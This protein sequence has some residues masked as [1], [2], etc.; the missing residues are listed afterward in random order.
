MWSGTIWQIGDLGEPRIQVQTPGPTAG[1]KSSSRVKTFFCNWASFG[2]GTNWFWPLMAKHLVF[3]IIRLLCPYAKRYNWSFLPQQ[4]EQNV[5]CLLRGNASLWKGSLP[6]PLPLQALQNY[7]TVLTRTYVTCFIILC[8]LC[9]EYKYLY[10]YNYR[11]CT[12][13][14]RLHLTQFQTSK[15]QIRRFIKTKYKNNEDISHR[16]CKI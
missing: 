3:L 15:I 4:L 14:H 10:L 5:H 2:S 8:C 9:T 7:A 1:C 12:P 11:V 6:V 16:K 13:N